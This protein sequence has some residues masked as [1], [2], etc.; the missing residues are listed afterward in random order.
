M[1]S[2]ALLTDDIRAYAPHAARVEQARTAL[3][4]LLARMR[5]HGRQTYAVCLFASQTTADG[6]W[7]YHVV[8]P[9]GTSVI[10]TQRLLERLSQTHTLLGDR[11]LCAVDGPAGG[12]DPT[13]EPD[14]PV[15]YIEVAVL[16]VLDEDDP[17]SLGR[18]HVLA[19]MRACDPTDAYLLLSCD[20][21]PLGWPR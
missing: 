11:I 10:L 13:L 19:R 2:D 21:R 18:S 9:A 15:G 1:I 7:R 17:R 16:I 3:A 14:D 4:A 20:A 8:T 12:P 6:A 5:E